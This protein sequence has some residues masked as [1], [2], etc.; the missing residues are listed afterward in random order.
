MDKHAVHADL[1]RARA[2]FHE[3]LDS[4]GPADLGQPTNGT[5]WTNKQL[6]FHM[7]LGYLIIPALLTLA[8][9]LSHL[10]ASLSRA[11]A[12]LLNVATRPFDAM[13]YWAARLAGNILTLQRMGRMFDCITAVLHRMLDSTRDSEL[14][15]GMHY[16]TK[17]D[18]FFTDFMTVAD[19]FRFPTRHFDFHRRQLTLEDGPL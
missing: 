10:P 18:P 7:L 11:F 15:R 1:D 17:W 12:R 8:W 19:I 13:N 4:A 9:L 3:L 6:L 5:R 16:P 14:A 2:T